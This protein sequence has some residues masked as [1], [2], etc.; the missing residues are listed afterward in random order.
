[1]RG[2]RRK[3]NNGLYARFC[4]DRRLTNILRA[5]DVCLFVPFVTPGLRTHYQKPPLNKFALASFTHPKVHRTV[6]RHTGQRPYPGI[7]RLAKSITLKP[8]YMSAEVAQ[9]PHVPIHLRHF[10]SP[11]PPLNISYPRPV[12]FQAPT[13]PSQR[14]Y[15]PAS[16]AAH[17]EH[18][19]L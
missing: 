4:P 1:M 17:I 7:K 10:S 9:H 11:R 12:Q 6:L 19:T 16:P 3:Y 18:P 5:L 8:Y 2:K 14:I 13:Q 15:N